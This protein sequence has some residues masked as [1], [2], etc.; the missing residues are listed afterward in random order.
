MK[1][2]FFSYAVAL[3]VLLI[4]VSNS[5]AQETYNLK[6]KFS[7]GMTFNYRIETSTSTTQ[8][9]MGREVKTSSNSVNVMNYKINDVS[10][11][12][13]FEFNIKF[14]TAYVKSSFMGRDT[15]IELNDLVGK[16]LGMQM[17]SLGEFKKL[18]QLDTI[19]VQ[20]QMI[21]FEQLLKRS[22][23]M[24]PGKDL[25][26]G[27]SWNESPID[28]ISIKNIGGQIIDTMEVVYTLAG[29]ENKLG[30]NCYKVT[31]T[32]NIKLQG[33]GNVQGM[34]LYIEGTGKM[35]GTVYLDM[36][37]CMPVYSESNMDNDMTLATTGQQ[38]MVI[39]MTQSSKTT[40]TLVGN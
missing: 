12:G 14:D 36:E 23:T 7:K 15:T 20:G 22:V 31:S 17:S 8:E 37:S 33:K 3:T 28:S 34:D 5:S 21:P 25:K 6:Y 27:D 16:R 39:P 18:E 4:L 13:D 35:S 2:V 38:S 32:G 1:K 10:D 9:A 29:T 24:F 30:Y 19:S 40:Q 26:V 11:N